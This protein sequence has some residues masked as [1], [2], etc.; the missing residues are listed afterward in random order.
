MKFKGTVSWNSA[1]L[2]HGDA[3]ESYFTLLSLKVIDG[4]CGGGD[5]KEGASYPFSQAKPLSDLFL[6]S[7]SQAGGDREL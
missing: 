5:G 4:K 6:S 7:V 1:S 2:A 3:P